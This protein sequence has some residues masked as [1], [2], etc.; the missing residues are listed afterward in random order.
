MPMF[1]VMHKTKRKK[2]L[3]KTRIYEGGVSILNDL[4]SSNPFPGFPL[5]SMYF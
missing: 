3:K 2:I 4:K 1:K 5:I